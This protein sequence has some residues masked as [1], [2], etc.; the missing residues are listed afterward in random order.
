[1]LQQVFQTIE[2]QAMW[3]KGAHLLVAVS[4]GADSMAL[5][6]ALVSVQRTQRIRLTV[7]HLHHGIRARAADRDAAF[8]RRAADALGLPFVSARVDVPARAAATGESIE[9]AARAA[10]YEFFR[11]VAREVDAYAVVTA[12][13]ADDQAETL[14]LRLLRGSGLQGLGGIAPVT[15]IGGVR[16]VRPLLGI[17]RTEIELFLRARKIEWREDATNRDAA[18]LRNRVRHTLLPLLEK[19]FQPAIRRL[20]CRTAEVLREDQNVIAPLVQRATARAK[21]AGGGLSVPALKK[22]KPALRHRV[23]LDWLRENGV[24]EARIGFDVVSRLDALLAR[25]GSLNL[26]KG[27]TLRADATALSVSIPKKS[28]AQKS[29]R[30]VALGTTAEIEWGSLRITA[31]PWRGIIRPRAARVGV[32]PCEASVRLPKKGERLA[33][34]AWRAGDRI[35]PVGMAGSVKLQDLF[36]DQKVPQVERANIPVVVC[37][38]RVVWVPGYRVARTWAVSGE[39]SRSVRVRVEAK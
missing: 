25:G 21:R 12:H 30:A 39:N 27:L 20:L 31:S 33:I 7:A 22:L 23:V 1:M 24:P 2:R 9:M 3:P 18:Y 14:L 36:V 38:A 5:L 28:A 6:Y 13:T 32:F 19:E 15:T 37:G 29:Q 17:S 34:R 4:G 26:V 16:L 35:A 8:V 10:R 11:A